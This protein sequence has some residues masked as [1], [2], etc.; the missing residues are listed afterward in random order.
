M[1]TLIAM[2]A[3]LSLAVSAPAAFAEH[4][5]DFVE[6]K[7]KKLTEK[8]SL[9]EEQSGQVRAI[10]EAKKEKMA[11]LTMDAHQ[12]IDAILTPEQ[13]EKFMKWKEEKREKYLKEHDGDEAED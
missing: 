12:Q 3:A 4:G 8:L 11:A 7:T 2:A 10:L 1:K 13:K 9:S 6:K 5:A